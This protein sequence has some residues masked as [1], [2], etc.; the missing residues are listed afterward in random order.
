MSCSSCKSGKTKHRLS[1][2]QP[3]DHFD[4]SSELEAKGKAKLLNVVQNILPKHVNCIFVRQPLVLVCAVLLA[5]DLIVADVPITK[6]L[7]DVHNQTLGSVLAVQDVPRELTR[8]YG[9]VAFTTLKDRLTQV[10]T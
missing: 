2:A 7:V 5:D 1:I 4:V 3:L 8:Q 9:A 6:Q 10:P